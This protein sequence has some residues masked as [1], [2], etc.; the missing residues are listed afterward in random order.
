[1]SALTQRVV[2]PLVSYEIH[3]DQRMTSADVLQL[4]TED[5]EFLCL[6]TLTDFQKLSAAFRKHAEKLV[7]ETP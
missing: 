3:H 5:G 2:K 1:M 4:N 7:R 6:L